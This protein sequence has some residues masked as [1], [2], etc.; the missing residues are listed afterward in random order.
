MDREVFG[1][2]LNSSPIEAQKQRQFLS[3]SFDLSKTSPI[4]DLVALYF[5]PRKFFQYFILSKEASSYVLIKALV[6][7]LFFNLLATL[8]TPYHELRD[9]FVELLNT[10]DAQ[11]WSYFQS[12]TGVS[13]LKEKV[14]AM[15]VVFSQ[16]NMFVSSLLTVGSLFL[17]A[18]L[19]GFV[20]QLLGIPSKS[21]PPVGMLASFFLY[22]SWYALVSVVAFIGPPLKA[23]LFFF[24]PIY[25]VK[26]NFQL[27]FFK[28]L[29]ATQALNIS[30]SFLMFGL[31]FTMLFV[32]GFSL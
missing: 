1:P 9:L 26:K 8:W 18:A 15:V 16:M 25:W 13:Q 12:R 23:L 11:S 20:L 5:Y 6:G 31:F 32:L 22:V 24:V 29:F 3:A 14:L 10:I 2:L 21:I 4:E 19:L 30:L 27:S 7:A 17:S 28:S